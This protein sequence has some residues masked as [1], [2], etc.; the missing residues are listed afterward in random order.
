MSDKETKDTKPQVPE[1]AWTTFLEQYQPSQEEEHHLHEYMTTAQIVEILDKICPNNLMHV[2]VF[3]LLQK[4]GF[5]RLRGVPGDVF[6]ILM[7]VL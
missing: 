4:S 7:P 1:I 6:W 3:D 2:D 5:K